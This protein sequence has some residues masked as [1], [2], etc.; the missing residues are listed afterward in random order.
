MR[1]F[2]AAS[3]THPG[4][5]AFTMIGGQSRS[6]LGSFDLSSHALSS[7]STALSGSSPGVFALAVAG[8]TVYASGYFSVGGRPP[9]YAGAVDVTTG[10]A[11]GWN[12]SM[13]C[14]G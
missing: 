7:W 12:T 3:V 2:D 4:Y 5:Q 9:D 10:N 13:P 6:V 14:V 8:N 11:V 1:V